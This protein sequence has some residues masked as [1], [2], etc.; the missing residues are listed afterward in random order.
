MLLSWVTGLLPPLIP[1][2]SAV[3]FSLLA[4][5]VCLPACLLACLTVLFTIRHDTTRHDTTEHNL[6]PSTLSLP[7]SLLLGSTLRLIASSSCIWFSVVMFYTFSNSP[8]G[9][10][11]K[12]KAST[13]KRRPPPFLLPPLP[14]TFSM[15]RNSAY[16]YPYKGDSSDECVGVVWCSRNR[17]KK[18]LSW[19]VRKSMKYP[20]QRCVRCGK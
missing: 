5:S 20:R 14:T 10:K 12:K 16:C 9:K 6:A 15:L 2:I 18:T 7:L 19:T 8:K 11:R 1:L 13:E 4:F 3:V 17:R